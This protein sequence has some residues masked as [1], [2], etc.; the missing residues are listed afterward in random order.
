MEKAY[1]IKSALNISTD[2]FGFDC[3]SS[4]KLQRINIQS[5][6]NLDLETMNSIV[7]V[8]NENLDSFRLSVNL[9]R[10]NINATIQ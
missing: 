5:S 2:Q 4:G 3:D 8:L 7:S 10:G 9:E 1:E 6:D